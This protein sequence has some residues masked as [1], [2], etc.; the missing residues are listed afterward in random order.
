M[1]GVDVWAVVERQGDEAT[2]VRLLEQDVRES[3][4]K[5]AHYGAGPQ[6]GRD[7]DGEQAKKVRDS[8]THE[9]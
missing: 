1:R 2:C 9:L 4:A 6:Q 5:P 8:L 7:G 3:P